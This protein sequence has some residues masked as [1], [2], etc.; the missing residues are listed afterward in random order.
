MSKFKVGDTVGII[1]KSKWGRTGKIVQ[2][3]SIADENYYKVEFVST[4]SFWENELELK[5]GEEK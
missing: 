3:K 4:Q 2:I 5:E 1:S